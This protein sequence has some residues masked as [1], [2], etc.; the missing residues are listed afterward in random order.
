MNLCP[1][2]GDYSPNR[3]LV[4]HITTLVDA[5]SSPF[6]WCDN[7]T[8]DV[9]GRARSTPRLKDLRRLLERAAAIGAQDKGG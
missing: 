1:H 4:D 7:V 2:W 3:P 5:T 9:G 8:A 6:A